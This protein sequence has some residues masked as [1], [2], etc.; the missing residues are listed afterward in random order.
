MTDRQQ[1]GIWFI[2]VGIALLSLWTL[3]YA[4]VNWA[5]EVNFTSINMHNFSDEQKY[6]LGASGVVALQLISLTGAPFVMAG[7]AQIIIGRPKT[8]KA[9]RK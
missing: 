4:I 9:N 2:I 1:T 7:V 6:I 5:V 8:K 3:S